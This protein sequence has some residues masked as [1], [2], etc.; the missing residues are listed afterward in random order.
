ML[1][2]SSFFPQR[3]NIQLLRFHHRP[4]LELSFLRKIVDVFSTV[5]F[6]TVSDVFRVHPDFVRTA[7]L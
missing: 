2:V 5:R 3:V 1:V 7:I 6:H 4:P